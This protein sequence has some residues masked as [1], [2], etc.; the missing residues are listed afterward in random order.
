M[1]LFIVISIVAALLAIAAYQ[2][3][4]NKYYWGPQGPPKKDERDK[5]RRG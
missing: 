1:F 4:L 5:K 3:V 2:V